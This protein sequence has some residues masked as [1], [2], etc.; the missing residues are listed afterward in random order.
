MYKPIFGELFIDHADTGRNTIHLFISQPTPLEEKNLG[1]AFVLLEFEQSIPD[2]DDIIQRLDD[3][4]TEAFYRSADFEVEAAFERALQKVNRTVQDIVS[5]LG[6]D[7]VYHT[8]A[9]LGVLHG[10]HIYLTHIGKIEG[11]LI[12]GDRITNIIESSATAEVKPLKLFTNI[13]SGQCPENG[14]M[15]FSTSNLLDYLSLEKIRRTVKDNNPAEATEYLSST[16]SAHDT[17]SNIAA[18]IVKYVVPT[19]H[20]TE[21]ELPETNDLDGDN[22]AAL[23]RTTFTEPADSMSKLIHQERAT[24]DLL[25]PSIWPTVKKRLQ[26]VSQ[27]QG[28]KAASDQAPAHPAARFALLAWQFILNVILQIASGLVWIG[29]YLYRW[30][31]KIIK[32]RDSIS[33]SVGGSVSGV[34]GWWK[35]LSGPQKIFLGLFSLAVVIFMISVLTKHSAV[36]QDDQ[37]TQYAATMTQVQNLLSEVESKQIMK[38]DAGAR[39]TVAQADQLLTTIPTDSTTYKNGGADLRSKIDGYNQTFN[40]VTPVDQLATVADFSQLA[41]GATLN[42]I[43]KIGNN[44]FAFSGTTD[45]VYRDNLDTN[46][47]QAAISGSGTVGYGNIKNDSAATTLAVQ[48]PNSF[49]QFNP[50]L[51]KNSPVTVT[52]KDDSTVVTDFNI[53]A[54]KLYVLDATNNRIVRLQKTKDTYNQSQPWLTDSTD[55]SKAVS[56][57]IDGSIYVLGSDGSITKLDAGKKS[58]FTPDTFSPSLAGSVDIIKTDPSNPFYILNPTTKRIVILEPNGKLRTQYTNDAFANAMDL[59]VDEAAGIAYVLADNKVYSVLIK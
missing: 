6:E 56:F 57:D 21:V 32:N 22:D 30:I 23:E 35:K 51:E 45:G 12:H 54:S 43:T 27:Y 50:V 58:Q 9:V 15:I 38:D 24:G 49:V 36:K 41:N 31:N 28:T 1:R 19:A 4:F 2:S 48:L 53:F 14:G 42:R 13:V 10:T 25:A 37:S 55:V 44:I 46:T 18:I 8:N 7:W 59:Y 47:T 17:L 29:K 16:L 39:A 40:K 11:K 5:Q 52:F 3:S 33:S 20:Q 34:S 26:S